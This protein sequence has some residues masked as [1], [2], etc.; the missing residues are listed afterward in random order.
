MGPAMGIAGEHV[1]M[2]EVLIRVVDIETEIDGH[3][4]RA[5]RS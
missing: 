3:N 2:M 1:M 4:L 5:F